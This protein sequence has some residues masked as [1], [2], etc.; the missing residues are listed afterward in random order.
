MLIANTKTTPLTGTDILDHTR[1]MEA[2]LHR[3][4]NSDNSGN[5]LTDY[6]RDWVGNTNDIRLYHCLD[7]VRRTAAVING[8][9][10]LTRPI[11]WTPAC[12]VRNLHKM[13]A[14]TP[15]AP[16]TTS[17]APG[18]PT[19]AA[20]PAPAIAPAEAFTITRLEDPT[21]AL[22]D[23]WRSPTGHL[24]QVQAEVASLSLFPADDDTLRSD[25]AALR[26]LADGM[27]AILRPPH[28]LRPDLADLRAGPLAEF[29]ARAPA[30]RRDVQ[31]RVRSGH[32]EDLRRAAAVAAGTVV[33]HDDD[34]DGW[35]DDHAVD[36]EEWARQFESDG[37]E[38][39]DDESG[40]LAGF[41]DV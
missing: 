14:A 35:S 7:K 11:N 25:Y 12:V 26:S 8:W 22:I 30:F 1:R 2:S 38:D 37:D 33:L 40:A 28:R 18:A 4:F 32:A 23:Q 19:T 20:A 13:P 41:D 31:A 34:E 6:R 16:T 21:N 39:G 10:T 17:Q 3:A 29:W 9:T 15:A 5:P 36:V 24:T 27:D